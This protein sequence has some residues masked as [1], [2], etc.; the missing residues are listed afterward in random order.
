M[1]PSR[2]GIALTATVLLGYVVALVW[3][4]ALVPPVAGVASAAA[5][6]GYS[7]PAAYRG[8][9]IWS[10][11]VLLL[12]AYIGRRWKEPAPQ[13]SG[14]SMTG[15][16]A[17]GGSVPLWARP[18]G[19]AVAVGVLFLLAY[20]PPVLSR[21]GPFV[22][23]SLMLSVLHRM[24]AGQIPY[25]DFE[26]LYGPLLIYPA[27]WW[28][29]VFG[30]SMGSYYGFYSLVQAV[31]FGL[32]A[33]VLLRLWRSAPAKGWLSLLV[34]TP[35]F[36]DT[37][38]GINWFG[39]RRLIPLLLLVAAAQDTHS[40]KRVVGLG[41][42]AGLLLAYS[43]D[44]AV[45]TLLA[46]AALFAVVAFSERS[47]ATLVR[48]AVVGGLA[49]LT[50]GAA[51]Y[52][53]LGPAQVD[54]ILTTR[55]LVGRFSLG[56]AGF[57]FYWTLGSL[58]LFAL[59][60]GALVAVGS[61]LSRIGRW[62]LSSGDRLL[63]LATVYAL[64]L[65]KAG[66]NRADVFHITPPFL[67][68][69][70]AALLP[71]P[72][73]TFRL[74]SSGRRVAVV[75]AVVASLCTLVGNLP[76]GSYLAQ[77]EIAGLRAWIQAT[78]RGPA[79]DTRTRT[80]TI[81]DEQIDPDAPWQELASFLA[82]P[83]RS[84]RPVYFYG[85]LYALDKIVGVEKRQY[86]N[87]DFM[88]SDERGEGERRFLEDNPTALVLISEGQWRRVRDPAS[89]D[90][91]EE[92]AAFL[93]PTATKRLVGVL[94]SVHFRGVPAELSAREERWTRTVGRYLIEAGYRSIA[95]FDDIQVLARTDAQTD[96][97]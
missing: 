38:L 62:R 65:L 70:F 78:P 77:G 23:D 31:G 28:M 5:V 22:E 63:L 12:L 13:E 30:Y 51:T 45:G 81:M 67:G 34:L 1:T 47:V 79:A 94:S 2:R 84:D 4:P 27:H 20:F 58:A 37:L 53:L 91:V 90:P 59:L 72:R 21:S 60:S 17:P 57:R 36:L 3:I 11:A 40:P 8:A 82:Q 96:A 49:V 86:M 14:A 71:L 39:V 52:A 87:D 75:A 92:Y 15:A 24:A 74:G 80:Y 6:E 7:N 85:R 88:Y 48:G 66:L 9:M 32:L 76:G 50:W 97:P 26:F 95:Q 41:V 33:W 16:A 56:E 10:L 18:V 61:Q 83:Q 64:I 73:S 44:Y 42:G 46:L 89:G 54:Y 43:H 69:A 35:F 68:L 29:Q 19:G 55:E 93:E 25:T